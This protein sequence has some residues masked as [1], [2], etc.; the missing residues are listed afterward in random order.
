MHSARELVSNIQTLVSLPTVYLRV[1]EQLDSPS[2]STTEVA[3]AVSAD[4]ALTARL[5]RVVNSAFYSLGGEIDT[6]G[7]AVTILGL[8]QVHDLVLAMSIGSAFAGITPKHLDTA[9]FWRGSVMCGLATREV[10]RGCGLPT[11]ERLFVVGLLAD[12]GHLVIHQTLP[13]LAQEARALAETTEEPLH[14]IEQR[15]IGCDYSEVGATLLNQWRLPLSFAEVVGAQT[16]PRL[17]GE[18]AYEAAI[19]HV[20]AHIVRADQRC[21]ASDTAAA[22]IDPTI[23]AQL[24]MGPEDL[25]PIRQ[26]CELNLA[27][28]VSLFFPNLRRS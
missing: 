12:I 9:Q 17:G 5:L 27:A 1:R 13:E 25:A 14:K 11:A 4:P 20:A 10:G 15:I 6:L 24:E 8:Q 7:R 21:E 16:N 19:V 18:N 26:E 28:Y 23:W 3:R 22:R 2:G